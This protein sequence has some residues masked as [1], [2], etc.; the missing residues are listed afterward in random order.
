MYGERVRTKAAAHSRRRARGTRLGAHRGSRR[1]RAWARAAR[2]DGCNGARA[3]RRRR[4]EAVVA[5]APLVEHAQHDKGRA[6]PAAARCRPPPRVAAAAGAPPRRGGRRQRV[7]RVRGLGAVP[8][9]RGLGSARRRGRHAVVPCALASSPYAVV[10]AAATARERPVVRQRR[11]RPA[12]ARRRVQ[13][14]GANGATPTARPQPRAGGRVEGGEIAGRLV[15]LAG[16]AGASRRSSVIAATPAAA[17]AEAAASL[18]ARAKI[19]R[20]RSPQ[21]RARGAMQRALGKRRHRGQSSS[22]NSHRGNLR[23]GRGGH[24]CQILT[25]FVAADPRVLDPFKLAGIR[26]CHGGRGASTRHATS[27]GS[28]MIWSCACSRARRS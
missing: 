1:P 25:P 23:R 16:G 9:V 2:G 26:T 22:H 7:E 11:D 12:V 21:P 15:E 10:R 13:H 28:A 18:A 17:R 8:R 4:R 24:L 20:S 3:R 14:I 27:T 6:P 5:G 19:V